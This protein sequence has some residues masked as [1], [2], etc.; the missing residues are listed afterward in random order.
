MP[1]Q[2][3]AFHTP[4]MNAAGMLGY[5][6]DLRRFPQTAQLGCFITNPVSRLPRSPAESRTAAH[7]AGG[8]LVHTGFPN[9]GLSA[10]IRQNARSWRQSPLPVL[11]HL[12]VEHVAGLCECLQMLD[13]VDGLSGLELSFHP[14]AA[15]EDVLECARLSVREWPVVIELD[16]HQSD[17]ILPGLVSCD[18]AAV[19]C[20]PLR[21]VVPN[22]AAVDAQN[23]AGGRIYGPGIFPQ[24][25][26]WLRAA[27]CHGLPVIAAGGVY[28]VR[29][30][31]LFL[32]AGA[33][34]VKLDTVLWSG[35]ISF[36]AGWSPDHH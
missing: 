20:A 1:K 4:V 8:S 36:P 3:L 12:M 25:M 10:V 35:G 27:R 11:L 17:R 28:S 14:G 22:A 33:L 9:P 18:V 32:Q 30:A 16:I 34:A 29:E 6:P 19:C 24:S 5:T 31:D 21:G 7:F 13:G 26:Y 2:D 15:I 23:L